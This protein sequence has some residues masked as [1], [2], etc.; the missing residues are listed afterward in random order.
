MTSPHAAKMY[1]VVLVTVDF[2]LYSTGS[3]EGKEQL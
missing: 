3:L 1:M 2:V